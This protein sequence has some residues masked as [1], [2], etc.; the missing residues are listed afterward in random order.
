MKVT[1]YSTPTCPWCHKVKDYLE[2][3]EVRFKDVNVAADRLGAMEMIR[4]S[5]QSGVPVVDI[6]GN[7]VIGFDQPKIDRLLRTS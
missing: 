4:K 1:V 6:N 2:Y 5:G 3:K 7:M